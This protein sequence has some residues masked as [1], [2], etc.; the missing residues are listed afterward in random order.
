MN[1]VS[2]DGD[3]LARL[4]TAEAV[5]ACRSPA[6][7]LTVAAAA[8]IAGLDLAA[9]R[10]LPQAHGL[11]R[12]L[13]LQ[14]RHVV[15]VEGISLLQLLRL[16]G[17]APIE[18]GTASGCR[19]DELSAHLALGA[20]AGLF[21]AEGVAPGELPA[22]V[23]ACRE[24]RV[25]A[26]VLADPTVG[27]LAALDAG[28]EL[29]LVDVARTYGGPALGLIVGREPLVRACALQERGLGA[30]FRAS[31]KELEETVAVVEAAAVEL[32]GGRAVPVPERRSIAPA[33][34]A[35]SN[36]AGGTGEDVRP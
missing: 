11:E 9:V 13:V 22:F 33:R 4:L 30:L 26:L 6:G 28:A 12:R 29:V 25:P 16:A 24:A 32:A 19:T 34:A 7:A 5:H 18:V 14:R 2:A 27:P 1:E 8:C 21:L 15:E 10:R 3:L 20:A 23:W 36:V 17:A 31:A 35:L